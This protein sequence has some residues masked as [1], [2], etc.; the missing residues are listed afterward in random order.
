MLA[1][2]VCLI[3]TLLT[4]RAKEEFFN[5]T[6]NDVITSDVN[7]THPDPQDRPL[8]LTFYL[9]VYASKPLHSRPIQQQQWRRFN[10][11][12]AAVGSLSR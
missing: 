7:A 8:N 5:R 3:C 6:A 4:D 2:A 9:S 10:A 1:V 12:V 11:P